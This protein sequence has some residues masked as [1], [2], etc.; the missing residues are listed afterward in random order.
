MPFPFVAK[1]NLVCCAGA[2]FGLAPFAWPKNLL[3]H[4]DVSS[5]PH[6]NPTKKNETKQPQAGNHPAKTLISDFRST[7][8]PPQRHLPTLHIPKRSLFRRHLRDPLLVTLPFVAI[9]VL[10]L[11]SNPVVNAPVMVAADARGGNPGGKKPNDGAAREPGEE[12]SG[13]RQFRVGVGESRSR[14]WKG[15]N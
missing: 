3:Q 15:I 6:H 11:Q 1:L 13:R 4:H 8:H 2:P 10:R 7:N 5:I 12:E 14:G 9:V